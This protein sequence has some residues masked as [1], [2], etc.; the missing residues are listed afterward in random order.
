MRSYIE[1]LVLGA[2]FGISFI[3]IRVA[4]P[5]FGVFHLV[6]TR[7]LL[8]LVVLIPA[9]VLAV[10]RGEPMKRF[11]AMAYVGP[12]LL[13]MSLPAVLV[14]YAGRH[15]DASLLA[16]LHATAPLFTLGY[17]MAFLGEACTTRK[18]IGLSLGV[19]GVILIVGEAASFPVAGGSASLAL[20][21]CVAACA[22][23]GLGNV[24]N[25]RNLKGAGSLQIAIGQ[26]VVTAA[27]LLPLVLVSPQPRQITGAAAISALLLGILCTGFALILFY[28]LL[29]A[30]GPTQTMMVT[31]LVPL[32]GCLWAFILLAERPSVL[33]LFGMA[34][35]LLGSALVSLA[36]EPRAVA[37]GRG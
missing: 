7:A 19:A 26:C 22:M 2:I 34:V 37:A 25:A 23:Y 27:L 12:A 31:F 1:L 9:Y 6:E 8:A 4:A 21:A 30:I 24:L 16:M 15:L 10:R 3:F 32:F 20:A 5:V 28:R 36:P 18:F 11:S 29:I 14:A 13:A 17:A 33:Q 35:V